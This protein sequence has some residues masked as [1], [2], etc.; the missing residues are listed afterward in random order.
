M[1]APDHF[2]VDIFKGCALD[3]EFWNFATELR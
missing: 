1:C 3:I 2:E